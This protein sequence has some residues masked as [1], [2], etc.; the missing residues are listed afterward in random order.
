MNWPARR[1]PRTVNGLSDEDVLHSKTQK[2]AAEQCDDV[3]KKD[4]KRKALQ[5]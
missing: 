3:D 1:L 5:P 4:E 2:R